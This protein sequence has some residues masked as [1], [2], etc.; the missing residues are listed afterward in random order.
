MLKISDPIQRAISLI[1]LL[2]TVCAVALLIFTVSLLT[3]KETEE[4]SPALS[5][6]AS[7]ELPDDSIRALQPEKTTDPALYT[8]TLCGSEL[9]LTTA[10]EPARYTVLRDI[11]PR[12]LRLE[13]KRVLE[14]GLPLDS[15]DALAQFLEDFSS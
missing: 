8:V 3:E 14:K 4:D 10:A 15:E 11:D 2:L 9:R 13:D 1:T 7:M 5:V 12:T 6:T